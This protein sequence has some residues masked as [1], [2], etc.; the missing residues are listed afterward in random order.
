MFLTNPLADHVVVL[1][2]ST[3]SLMGPLL[4]QSTKNIPVKVPDFVISTD[5]SVPL[6]RSRNMNVSM[7]F[8]PGMVF[9]AKDTVTGLPAFMF[10][11][12]EIR[13]R[14]PS[15]FVSNAWANPP[16]AVGS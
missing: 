6:S 14:F 4:S 12:H 16:V 11:F 10:P 5:V 15:P 13:S 3:P 9:P 1:I 8:I 2:S 7:K